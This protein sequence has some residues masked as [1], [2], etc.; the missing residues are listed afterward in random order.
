M[1]AR[2]LSGRLLQGV[3]TLAIASFVI[4]AAVSLTPGGALVAFSGV[5]GHHPAPSYVAAL[6]HEFH[7]NQP[8]IPRYI[9]WLGNALH[10]DLGQSTVSHQAVSS[11]IG[12]RLPTTLLLIGMASVIIVIVGVGMGV[13]AA[14]RGGAID[15]T[16]LVGSVVALA[17]PAFVAATV[18][19]TVFAVSLHW[20]PS[21]GAG[22]GV[23]GRLY[24]LTLPAIALALPN[25]AYVARVVR[26]S[27]REQMGKEFV[28]TAVARGLARGR[29][30]RKHIVRNAAI[31]ILTVGG[32]TI[33]G[34][35]A[36]TVIVEQVF[37]LDGLG[38][39]MVQSVESNDYA[40]AQPTLMILVGA[41]IIIN[42]LM[43]IAYTALDPRIAATGRDS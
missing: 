36:W 15:M 24:H 12:S 16:I 13:L 1:T 43:D 25:C 32:L 39:L 26:S 22:S 31:P 3:I 29:V 9:W 5:L 8:L 14:L 6:T 4:F 33:A 20:F 34:L 38:S 41:F 40:V 18:L 17:T 23:A 42:T 19:I 7:L 35:F 37:G 10:G 11:M 30:I 2:A 27:V 28:E 21:L